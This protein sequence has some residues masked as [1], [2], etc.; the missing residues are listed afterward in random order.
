MGKINMSTVRQ[1]QLIM[2]DILIEV[3]RACKKHKIEYWLDFGTLLGSVR[4]KGFISWD[5]DLDIAM[6]LEDYHKFCSLIDTELPKDMFLQTNSTDKSFPYSYAKI[7]SSRGKIVEKHE[8]NKNI[9]YNQGIFIDIFPIIAIR[10][11]ILYKYLYRV[12]FLIVKLFSYKYLHIQNLSNFYI[13][14]SDLLHIGWGNKKSK[15]IRSA[16]M[17]SYKLY[18]DTANVFPLKKLMFENKEF[19]VPNNYHEYLKILYGENY[20]QLPPENKRHT[21]ASSLEIYE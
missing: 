17:P 10:K 1:A 15:V 21:H 8:E 2:L 16:R 5:D 14:V 6:T 7:R 4:E 11:N 13:K 12:N 3:D 9:I 20:M 18:I 19:F